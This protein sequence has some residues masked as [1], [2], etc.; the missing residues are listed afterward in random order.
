MP[1]PEKRSLRRRSRLSLHER[2]NRRDWDLT[3]DW[4]EHEHGP[5]LS[6][7]EG[8]AW[9]TFRLPERKLRLL[10][11]VRGKDIL[12][13]GCG[14][15]RWSIALIRAGARVVSLDL[16]P[17]R[18]EQARELAQEAGVELRLVEASAEDV[19]L[20]D[21]SF[22]VVF[23]D[24]GAMSFADPY[25]TVP[26]VA[27][28]LRPGGQLTFAITSP[29]NTVFWDARKDRL[30]DR[31]RRPYFGLHKMDVGGATEFQ[32]PYGEWIRLFVENGLQVEQLLETPKPPRV[33]S[34][35]VPSKEAGW[36]RRYPWDGI[37]SVRKRAPA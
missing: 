22:D 26:E 11:D 2:R 23:C 20:P 14:A 18:L 17:R 15:A 13:L 12:E 37:W 36:A 10:G 24:H 28:L 31:P 29:W 6:L 27:R 35:F 32:L 21:Q 9:G 1:T 16:S 34:S 8:M 7:H 33:R 3:A 25:R 19:P 4:F 30:A 5:G